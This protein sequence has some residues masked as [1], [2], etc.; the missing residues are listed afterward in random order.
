M[1]TLSIL[2]FE[3]DSRL[4][5]FF[6]FGCVDGQPH[7]DGDGVNGG[8]EHLRAYDVAGFVGVWFHYFVKG[9]WFHM[10]SGVVYAIL[11]LSLSVVPGVVSMPSLP[12]LILR[13]LCSFFSPPLASDGVF[14]EIFVH[15]IFVANCAGFGSGPTSEDVLVKFAEGPVVLAEFA[16]HRSSGALARMLGEYIGFDHLFAELALDFVVELF[17]GEVGGTSCCY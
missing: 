6:V 3:R 13:Y 9:G 4:L 14:L 5:L 1:Q 15:N 11:S 16:V 10:F 7:G 2:A 8:F 12:H 17:L